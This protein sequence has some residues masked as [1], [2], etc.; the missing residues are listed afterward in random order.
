MAL[1][2]LPATLGRLRGY[3]ARARTVAESDC[4]N[5][6]EGKLWDDLQTLAKDAG[7]LMT[8]MEVTTAVGVGD[9]EYVADRCHG[10]IELKIAGRV[11]EAKTQSEYTLAQ[12]QWLLSHHKPRVFLRSWLL[13]AHPGP[14][15]WWYFTLLEPQA[16]L[17]LLNHREPKT[18]KKL[19]ALPGVQVLTTLEDVLILINPRGVS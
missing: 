12:A 1:P 15:A 6:T 3:A 7:I 18:W 9:V 5:A 11:H 14:N 10:W 13:C 16:S 17:A 8:R 19:H 2:I 4:M